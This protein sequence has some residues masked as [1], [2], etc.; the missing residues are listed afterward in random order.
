V[1]AVDLVLL[2]L[3]AAGIQDE[4]DIRL[5]LATRDGKAITSGVDTAVTALPE[6][7]QELWKRLASGR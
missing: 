6:T 5:L 1:T 3:F 7:A 2:K 4:L